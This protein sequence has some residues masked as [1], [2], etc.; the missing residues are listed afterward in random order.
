MSL[1]II[2]CKDCKGKIET[3][4]S[5]GVT[6]RFCDECLKKRRRLSMN[7]KNVAQRAQRLYPKLLI[8]LTKNYILFVEG[9]KP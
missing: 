4:F 2:A 7:H 5:R 8:N 9:V 1:T 6:K 3:D